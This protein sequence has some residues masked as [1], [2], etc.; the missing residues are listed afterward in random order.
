[1]VDLESQPASGV[2]DRV[3]W[4][5]G[6]L[7]MLSSAR[8]LAASPGAAALQLP[9]LLGTGVPASAAIVSHEVTPST[10]EHEEDV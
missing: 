4:E 10:P 9:T 2:E 6:E 8:V 1:M 5:V 3:N 7:S